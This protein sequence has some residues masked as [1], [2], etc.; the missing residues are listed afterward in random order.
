M[1][2]RS[3][4]LYILPLAYED[5][6]KIGISH[7]PLGRA[8]A[9]SRRYYEFFDLPRS[10][11]IEFDSRREAQAR[12]TQLH[13]R[14]RELNAVQ[15]LTVPIRAA[16]ETEWYRGA[17]ASVRAEIDRDIAL[18][19]RGHIDGTAWWRDRLRIERE[20]LFEW[21]MQLF[22]D[23]VPQSLPAAERRSLLADA[24]DAYACLDVSLA[25][26]LPTDVEAWYR[27]YREAW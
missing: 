7:D 18:G 17:Y 23:D 8:Q 6:L 11:L 19:H 10:A 5:I 16:G 22:R 9:F 15:P 4:Y 13:R 27:G 21:S 20:V 2:S 3:C 26:A 24:L 14:L 12:E 1:K 25:D